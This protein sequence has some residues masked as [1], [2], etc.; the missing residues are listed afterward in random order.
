[1]FVILKTNVCLHLDYL[2]WKTKGN[3]SCKYSH[4]SD[5]CSYVS[6]YAM[7]SSYLFLVMDD[8]LMK[9]KIKIHPVNSIKVE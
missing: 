6:Y 7:S 5:V 8:S 3:Y 4:N 9:S 2:K 1:M